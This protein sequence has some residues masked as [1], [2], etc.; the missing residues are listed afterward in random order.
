MRHFSRWWES[1]FIVNLEVYIFPPKI[2]TGCS[3]S[4]ASAFYRTATVDGSEIRRSPVDTVHIL[5][6]TTGFHTCWCRISSINSMNTSCFVAYNLRKPQSWLRE[7]FFV[8]KNEPGC[9]R[10]FYISRDTRIVWET[11]GLAAF[12]LGNP[13][14]WRM[15]DHRIWSGKK[16]F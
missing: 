2:L 11:Q 6:K 15:R 8:T 12:F 14:G 16:G 4:N 10:R 1:G 7:D 9:L 13:R 3:G 5:Y